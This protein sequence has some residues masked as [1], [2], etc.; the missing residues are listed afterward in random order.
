MSSQFSLLGQRRF[1]PFF[2]TQFLGA[3]N[4]NVFKTALITMV[5]FK[6]ISFAGFDGKQL[7]TI[8]PGLFILPYFLFSATAL[9]TVAC[10]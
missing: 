1:L 9:S 5:S 2:G 3:F 10:P 7:S 4:D 8:L 6:A